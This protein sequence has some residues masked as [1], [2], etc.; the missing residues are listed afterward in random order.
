MQSVDYVEFAAVYFCHSGRTKYP[1]SGA[2]TGPPGQPELRFGVGV[3][4]AFGV[5]EGLGFGVGV[6]VGFGLGFGVGVGFGV[7]DGEA[8]GRELGG[9]CTTGAGMAGNRTEIGTAGDGETCGTAATGPVFAW[10]GRRS[11]TGPMTAPCVLAADLDPTGRLTPLRYA[12]TPMAAANAMAV[13]ATISF[14]RLISLGCAAVPGRPDAS[15]AGGRG[16]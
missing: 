12:V 15:S 14:R 10:A 9:G 2:E 6:G 3:G 13:S 5:G 16:T 4:L 8:A 1:A 7:G 11:P